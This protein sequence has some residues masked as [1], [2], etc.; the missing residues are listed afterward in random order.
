MKGC[1]WRRSKVDL[2][3]L[4]P[5]DASDDK[6]LDIAIAD[7]SA[8]LRPDFALIDGTVGMAGLGPSAG[9]PVPMGVV[10]AG[11]DA[12]ATDAVA[13]ALMGIRAADVPHLR[14]AAQR[15]H[16]TTDLADIDVRPHSW[17]ELARDFDLPPANL[18]IEFPNVRILDRN[19]CSACQSTVL[20]FLR[21]YR[22]R[23]FD[24]FPS[25]PGVTIAIGKGHDDVPDRTLCIGN[26]T[27]RHK[28]RGTFVAGCPPV[29]SAILK[30]IQG[31]SPGS[32]S[33]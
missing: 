12:F 3:M 26:C 7:M 10:L 14:I 4:P 5:S 28:T 20:L 25:D 23:I 31:E 19:S 17:R 9:D 27:A 21:R 2:H 24:Y 8:V 16:G 32:G 22:D 13:C 15:G 33:D 30:A 11:T 29:G 18:S 1:L 6:S